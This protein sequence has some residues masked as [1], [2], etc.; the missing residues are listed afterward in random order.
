MGKADRGRGGA[1]QARLEGVEN[2]TGDDKERRGVWMREM[3]TK[4]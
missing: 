3:G 2:D 4:L 1:G